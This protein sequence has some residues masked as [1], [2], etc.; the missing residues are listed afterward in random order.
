MWLRDGHAPRVPHPMMGIPVFPSAVSLTASLGT[1]V[2]AQGASSGKA[3]PAWRWFAH[4]CLR[5]GHSQARDQWG[6]SPASW[7]PW[8][9]GTPWLQSPF[10]CRSQGTSAV[11]AWPLEGWGPGKGTGSVCCRPWV[12]RR[13]G[14]C[15]HVCS[16]KIVRGRLE[17]CIPEAF[18]D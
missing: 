18:T 16:W 6:P 10:V 12:C 15:V 14:T 9:G 11:S 7:G 8:G 4:K 5:C 3:Q 1:S 17:D 13:V 2:F